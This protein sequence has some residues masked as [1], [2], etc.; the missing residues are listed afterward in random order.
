[1][2]RKVK[3]KAVKELHKFM[4]KIK[5]NLINNYIFYNW[6]ISN[7]KFEKLKKSNF[8]FQNNILV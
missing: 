8:L 5:L 7:N 4:T 1:M 3:N 2:D 6:K